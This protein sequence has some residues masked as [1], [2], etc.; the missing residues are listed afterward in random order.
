MKDDFKKAVQDS[1]DQ[2]YLCSSLLTDSKY[3]LRDA[4]GTEIKISR[5]YKEIYPVCVVSDH[6]PALSFQ[7]RQFLN[8]SQTEQI[9]PPFVMDVFLLDVLTE[10]LQSPLYFLSYLNRRA[11]YAEEILAAH[12]LTVLSYHL[13]QN[14]WMDG[15]CTMMHLGD[16]ICADLDLAMLVR[17]DGVPGDATPDGIL[18][19]FKG[20]HFE[21][22]IR[23][24]ETVAH[25]TTIELG[26]MLLILSGDTVEMLNDGIEK[27][28]NLVRK[29]RSHHDITLGFDEGKSGL[30]IHCNIDEDSV[31]ASRLERHCERR[32]Y[33]QKAGRWFGICISAAPATPAKIRFGLHLDSEW[34]RSEE[35]D[36]R[37]ADMPAPHL[38]KGK[39]R[40]NFS[41]MRA[42]RKVGRNDKCPC[43]SGKKYKKCCL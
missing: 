14:L 42:K 4:T 36:K 17:R 20:S 5:S 38:I 3:T 28:I 34:V 11:M 6:Y 10:M 24:I 29:D 16:D 1:Y 15:E 32:K 30:T 7:A 39:K 41:N 22:M 13:K 33:A 21:R 2:A 19:K 43:G 40:L 27:L 8:F 23:E 12:E 26:F 35:M 31:A 9:K 37:T 25:P 18:T